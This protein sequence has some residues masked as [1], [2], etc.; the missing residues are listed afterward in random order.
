MLLG[1]IANLHVV[2]ELDF[3]IVGLDFASQNSKQRCFARTVQTKHKQSFAPTQIETDVMKNIWATECF[4]KTI[5]GQNCFT[6]MWRLG[7]A[8]FHN[9]RTASSVNPSFFDSPNSFFDAVR[10]R[11]FAGFRAEPID[12]TL[13]AIDFFALLSCLFGLTRFICLARNQILRVGATVFNDQ[14]L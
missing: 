6:A 10:H 13:Q 8:N 1:V 3:T 14:A 9:S 7:K 5:N 12:N 2:A 11:G 4:S